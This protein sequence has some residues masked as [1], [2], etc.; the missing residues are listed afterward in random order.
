MKTKILI[1]TVLISFLYSCSVNNS[2]DVVVPAPDL[3]G[4]WNLTSVT[5]DNAVLSVTSPVITTLT[6]EGFGKNLNASM[7]FTENPNNVVIDGNFVFQ[8]TYKDANSQESTEDLLL[9]NLFFNDTFGFLSSSWTLNDNILTL[10]EGG[11]QLNINVISYIGNVITIETD[12]NK[13]ITVDN[14][15]STVTGKALLTIEKQ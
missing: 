7:T 11:E 1:A 6:G 3:V 13:A 8:L 15:T 5:M 9:D 4:T 12:V 14:V 2:S 10:N